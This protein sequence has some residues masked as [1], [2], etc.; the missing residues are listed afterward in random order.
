MVAEPSYFFRLVQPFQQPPTNN[1][2]QMIKITNHRSIENH[3]FSK[4]MEQ[5]FIILARR[6][7]Y[8]K[9]KIM[10]FVSEGSKLIL[11][12]SR[13]PYPIG[14]KLAVLGSTSEVVESH[15]LLNTR[16]PHICLTVILINISYKN[17]IYHHSL[18]R[19]FYKM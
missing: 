15:D 12:I 3:R 11:H 6:K 4:T 2:H 16:M 7:C 10:H 1:L 5:L 9:P 19:F 14:M 13:I 8:T 18:I 17:I